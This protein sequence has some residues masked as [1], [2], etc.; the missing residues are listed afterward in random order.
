MKDE[1]VATGNRSLFTWIIFV[2]DYSTILYGAEETFVGYP[3]RVGVLVST[4]VP[5]YRLKDPCPL[6]LHNRD[7]GFRSCQASCLHT[8]ATPKSNESSIVIWR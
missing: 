5:Q 4:A 3:E 2:L 8:S 6:Y 7:D 1:S